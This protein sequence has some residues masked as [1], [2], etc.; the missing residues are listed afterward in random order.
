MSKDKTIHRLYSRIHNLETENC[1][2]KFERHR[3]ICEV[4]RLK[5]ILDATEPQDAHKEA[6]RYAIFGTAFMI[7]ILCNIGFLSTLHW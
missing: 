1:D 5:R 7:S 3:A 6:I 4:C 2:L